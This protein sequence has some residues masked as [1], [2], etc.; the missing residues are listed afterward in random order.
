[1]PKQFVDIQTELAEIWTSKPF[2][3]LLP[4]TQ[5]QLKLRINLA[6]DYIA[7]W[8]RQLGLGWPFTRTTAYLATIARHTTGNVN[9]TQYSPNVTTGTTSPA[10]TSAMVGRL[11]IVDGGT[12]P[13]RIKTV[14]DANNI[15]LQTPYLKATAINKSYSI[16]ADIYDLPSDFD[17]IA[18]GSIKV[19]G[20]NEQLTYKKEDAFNDEFPNSVVIGTPNYYGF[21]DVTAAGLWRI[22]LRQGYPETVMG[23]QYKY[24]RMLPDLVADT[25]KSAIGYAQGGDNALLL[26][27]IWQL[28]EVAPEYDVNAR[29]TAKRDADQAI[30]I[31]WANA[32]R[33]TDDVSGQ[34]AMPPVFS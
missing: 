6:K 32:E 30:Q 33:Q 29:R 19:D 14:T 25:D 23:I 31:M 4:G 16:V 27:S 10:F 11:F 1:M 20:E 12:E 26:T 34:V 17:S 2:S 9:L 5:T 18:R 28:K 15:V 7:S 21:A 8:P 13:Y 22:W 3:A 24:Y